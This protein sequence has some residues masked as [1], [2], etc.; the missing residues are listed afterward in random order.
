MISKRRR[1]MRPRSYRTAEVETSIHL[2]KVEGGV[3]PQQ[4]LEAAATLLIEGDSN[5]ISSS[6]SN[7]N[8]K[9]RTISITKMRYR[10]SSRCIMNNNIKTRKRTMMT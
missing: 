8:L 7:S 6:S 1:T 9:W 2:P 3:Q 10:M 5:S 4:A